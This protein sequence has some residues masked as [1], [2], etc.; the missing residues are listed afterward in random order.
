M[1]I[2][3]KKLENEAWSVRCYH[4]TW[5]V[6]H[7][8][9]VD[10][11]SFHLNGDNIKCH[12]STR[13]TDSQKSTLTSLLRN[14]PKGKLIIY[15]YNGAFDSKFYADEIAEAVRSSEWNVTV[16]I[17]AGPFWDN[18]DSGNHIHCEDAASHDAAKILYSALKASNI[19]VNDNLNPEAIYK[20]APDKVVLFIGT[21]Y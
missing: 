15:A 6:N 13:M 12:T 1:P 9:C 10:K 16:E 8:N 4:H 14:K 3:R 21:K 2:S 17:G 11:F 18:G 20:T 7:S 19:S 5:A